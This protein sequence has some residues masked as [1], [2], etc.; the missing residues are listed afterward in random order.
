M[1]YQF[2]LAGEPAVAKPAATRPATTT[3]ATVK[4][5][6]AQVTAKPAAK[7]GVN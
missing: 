6:P 4:S 2:K 5:V 3:G 7:S 1:R